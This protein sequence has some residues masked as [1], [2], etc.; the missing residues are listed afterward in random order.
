MTSRRRHALGSRSRTTSTDADPHLANA[1][2]P[3]LPPAQG[4]ARLWAIGFKPI[5]LEQIG[6]YKDPLRASWPVVHPADPA[7]AR[8]EKR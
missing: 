5:P 4:L 3:R 2:T 6:L 1:K 8:D 7:P